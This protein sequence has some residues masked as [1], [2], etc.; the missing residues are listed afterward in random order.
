MPM[1]GQEVVYLPIEIFPVSTS[2]YRKIYKIHFLHI[3]SKMANFFLFPN[4]ELQLCCLE[5]GKG[6]KSY[7][8]GS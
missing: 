3:I 4:N 2:A 8:L 5:K 7:P 6:S 1:V